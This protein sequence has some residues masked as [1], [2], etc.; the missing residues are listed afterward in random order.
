VL[1][2]AII[3][4]PLY[5][6]GVGGK[7]ATNSGVL[8]MP[9]TLSWVGASVVSGVLI[10]RTGRY[11][12]YPIVGSLV[13]TLGVWLLTRLDVGS[14]SWDTT[15]AML[16]IGLAMGLMVQT[17]LLATQNAVP[18]QEI[19]AASSSVLFF[20]SFGGAFGTAA[21]GSILSTQLNAALP[22][23][24]GPA[25]SRVDPQRLLQA[26]S[27]ARD[28]PPELVHGVRVALAESL[29][30]VFLVCLPIAACT[31]IAALLLKELPLRTQTGVQQ[32]AQPLAE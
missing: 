25:T 5:V 15:V 6:Q 14:S 22:R 13:L 11:R 32:R 9:L 18:P 31:I 2:G 8:L 27:A 21:L 12:L 16:V 26:P 7:S 3:Y 24:L 29:H 23:Q 30:T 17:F 10:S 1:F 19:G 28:L 20:R 4:I